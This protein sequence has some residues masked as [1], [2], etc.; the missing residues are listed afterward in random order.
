M[1]KKWGIIII[2][3]VLFLVGLTEQIVY[4]TMLNNTIAEVQEIEEIVLTDFSNQTL[5]L[6]KIDTIKENWTHREQILCTFSNHKEIQD[7][8]ISIVKLKNATENNDYEHA[9]ENV[10]LII[11]HLIGYSHIYGTNFQNIF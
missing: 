10:D 11:F 2:V 6:Q 5:L 3:V 7:V 4:R 1:K 8:G 9:K